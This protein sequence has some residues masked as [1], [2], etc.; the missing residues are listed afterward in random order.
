MKKYLQFVISATILIL[1]FFTN[2][3]YQSGSVF[4]R[5]ISIHQTN[6]Q[7][8]F[9]L[10]Q[11]SWQANVYFSYDATI[12]NQ[13]NIVSV[14]AEDKSLYTI[15]NQIID[16][17]TYALQELDNQIIIS[18]KIKKDT[19]S[20]IKDSI[21]LPYFFLSGK[22]IENHKGDPVSYA[23]VSIYK[24]V[25]GTISN[26]DG[27]FV[28]K[29]PRSKINDTIIISSMGYKQLILPAWH[30]LDED[31]FILEPISIKIKEIKVTAISPENLLDNMR[32]NY[33]NNYTS[34]TKLMNAFYR[35]TVKQ[36]KS[37]ISV[38]E[39][40][41]EILKTPYSQQRGD[42]VRLL[43]A[44]KSPDVVPFKWL[45]FKLMGGPFTITELDAIKTEETFLDPKYENLYK[46]Q[47]SDVIWYNNFPVYV[48]KFSPVNSS[49]YPPFE[50]KMYVHR[51]TFALVHAEYKI[52][53]S[54]LKKAKNIMIKKKPR[55]VKAYPSYVHY[56][57]N[58]Q[59][60]QGKWHLASAKASV[61]FKVKSKKKR[62]NSVFHS[63]SE[64][65]ITNVNATNLKRFSKNEKFTKKDVFV[66]KL[67]KYD[68]SFWENYNT[69]KPD[70]DL[71]NAFN[72]NN[73]PIAPAYNND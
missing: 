51:E 12:I 5:R 20:L 64:I 30:L 36:N 1:P 50:G 48:V 69:I 38:S 49:F 27:E 19:N 44:R 25:T 66:E 11:I 53:K 70:E 34:S 46:Y 32:K 52:C 29:I 7:L 45:N 35:E 40:V 55:K 22:L 41:I 26:A 67:G 60:F 62:I 61:K 71:R 13:E 43:K 24:E 54:G 4:E 23:S 2:A 68:E 15:L 39:A 47:V 37:Y 21:P 72:P 57:V 56:S 31:I 33:K 18:Q 73:S 8:G 10:E 14:N 28:L 65:L 58:Y 6:Q 17:T 9:I 63:I 42:L 59:Q 3:Q 16:T